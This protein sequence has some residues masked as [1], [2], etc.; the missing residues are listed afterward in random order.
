MDNYEMS[1]LAHTNLVIYPTQTELTW[2]FTFFLIEAKVT[3]V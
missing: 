2:G 1:N 3:A